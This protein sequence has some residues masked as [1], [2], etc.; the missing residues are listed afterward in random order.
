MEY[1]NKKNQGINHKKYKKK[2]KGRVGS[3]R[4]DAYHSLR[5]RWIKARRASHHSRRRILKDG[6]KNGADIMWIKS[7]TNSRKNS[8]YF[9]YRK[10]NYE[11]FSKWKYKTKL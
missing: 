3:G 5:G 11:S 6:I 2:N 1:E 7:T 9:K 8:E 10:V 4:T